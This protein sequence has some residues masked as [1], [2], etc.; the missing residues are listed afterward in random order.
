MQT[1]SL[2]NGKQQKTLGCTRSFIDGLFLRASTLT[3][4]CLLVSTASLT[5]QSNTAKGEDAPIA[6]MPTKEVATSLNLLTFRGNFYDKM[7]QLTWSPIVAPDAVAEYRVGYSAN[8]NDFQMIGR[9]FPKLDNHYTFSSIIYHAGANYFKIVQINKDGTVQA[10]EP[11]NVMCGFPDRYELDFTHANTKI[12]ISLQ[13]RSDQNVTMEVLRPNGKTHQALFEGQM[14]KNEV[15]FRTI[16]VTNWK[17]GK[18]YLIINGQTF[19]ESQ[20]IIIN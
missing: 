6:L 9:V 18:Y 11:I 17:A 10:S 15:I 14:M 16:N 5:A 8:G 4:C 1:Y 19:R 13:V 20:E 12:E 7:I 2:N 3:L